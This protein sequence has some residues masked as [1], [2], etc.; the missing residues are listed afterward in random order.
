LTAKDCAI[1]LNK[2]DQ[3]HPALVRAVLQKNNNNIITPVA[4][5]VSAEVEDQLNN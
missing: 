5:T 3:T 1:K 2:V 4:T